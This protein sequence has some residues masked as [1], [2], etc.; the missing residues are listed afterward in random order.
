MFMCPTSE[1]PICPAGSP[2]ASP[3]AFSVV[4]G[5]RSIRR[6][7]AGVRASAMA[8]ASFR[9]LHPQPS[10]ITSTVGAAVVVTG[11]LSVI[12]LRAAIH[13]MR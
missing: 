10:K 2:T 1:L 12:R 8:L 6:V 13:A 4:W 11:K 5:Y 7:N 9:G 3:D